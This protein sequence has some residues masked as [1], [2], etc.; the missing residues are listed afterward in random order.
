MY[1]MPSFLIQNFDEMIS[2]LGLNRA[3]DL[4][5]LSLKSS[6]LELRNHSAFAEPSQVAATLARWTLRVFPGHLSKA[7]ARIQFVKDL[8]RLLFVL[9]QDMHSMNLFDHVT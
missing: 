2:K 4:A 8:F 5:F 6:L 1:H 3:D 9:A 7:L